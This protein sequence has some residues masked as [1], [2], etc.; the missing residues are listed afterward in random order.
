[1][2]G[3]SES[4]GGGGG[5]ERQRQRPRRDPR[6]WQRSEERSWRSM[7]SGVGTAGGEGHAVGRW[8]GGRARSRWLRGE[9]WGAS[10]G[11]GGGAGGEACWCVQG[12]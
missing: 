6:R 11:R 8:Q 10:G 2:A 12:G 5:R 7:T 1:M 9:V 3:H 4:R